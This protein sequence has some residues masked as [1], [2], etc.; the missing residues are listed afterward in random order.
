M[1]VP[2]D[3]SWKHQLPARID[4]LVGNI[5]FFE[6]GS[7]TNGANHIAFHHHR[8]IFQDQPVATHRNAFPAVDEQIHFLFIYSAVGLCHGFANEDGC[9]Q[10]KHERYTKVKYWLSH[11]SAPELRECVSKPV[12]KFE[13]SNGLGNNSR[14]WIT[15]ILPFRFAMLTGMSPQNSHISWRHAPQGGVSTSVSVTTAVAL[16][17]G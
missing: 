3:K 12:H 7:E 1:R 13:S 15:S 6:I 11:C 2:I 9:S 17:P 10:Q 14:I 16:N 8:A 5:F 4:C